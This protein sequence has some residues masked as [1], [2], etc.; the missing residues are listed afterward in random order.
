MNNAARQALK[1]IVTRY[2]AEAYENAPRCEA[3]LRD[4][5]G[6]YKREIFVLVSVLQQGV[7]GDLQVLQGQ[8]PQNVML[9][10]VTA[11]VR[12]ALA[13]NEEA[14]RWAVESWGIALGIFPDAATSGN[15]PIDLTGKIKLARLLQAHTAGVAGVAFSPDSAR[16][17]SVGLDGAARLWDVAD[18]Q[19]LQPQVEHIGL[20]TSVAF[21]PD[22]KLVAFGSTDQGVYLWNIAEP[23]KPLRRLRGHTAEVASLA[24]SPDGKYLASGGGDKTIWLWNAA[25][26]QDIKRLSGHADTVTGLAFS[27][28]GQT[29]ASAGGW[30]RTVRLWDPLKG[31]ELHKLVG[32]TAQVTGVAFNPDGYTLASCGWDETVRI[33]NAAK[34]QETACLAEQSDLVCLIFAVAYN[35]TGELLVTGSWDKLVRLWELPKSAIKAA[36][37]PRKLTAHEGLVSSVAFSPDGITLASAGQDGKLG[38]WR[39]EPR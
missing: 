9:A 21:N 11:E 29:L 24:F 25:T 31:R 13:L 23:D 2:G 6:Q 16:L 20:L 36:P 30:D 18:G 22:G 4:F 10:Q 37:A 15:A 5:A 32:H 39:L 3:F 19:A 33:W 34:G 27:P 17:I 8:V 26:G 1:Q 28:G 7:V 38:L 35:P 12:D 14:A